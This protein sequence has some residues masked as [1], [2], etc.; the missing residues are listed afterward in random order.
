MTHASLFH[1]TSLISSHLLLLLQQNIATI[2]HIF[3]FHAISSP[4]IVSWQPYFGQRECVSN[5]L[6]NSSFAVYILCFYDE[7][8]FYGL[9][10]LLLLKVIM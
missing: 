8:P 6:F 9:I 3:L 7:N 10:F 2:C 4:Q 5:S 1:T